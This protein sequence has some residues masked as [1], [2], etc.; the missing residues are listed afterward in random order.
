MT[1][2]PPNS[3]SSRIESSFSESD[4]DQ[5][6]GFGGGSHGPGHGS[7]PARVVTGEIRGLRVGTPCRA[8]RPRLTRL[9]FSRVMPRHTESLELEDPI[10]PSHSGS[11]SRSTL[12]RSADSEA[13]AT[14]EA[15]AAA[16]SDHTMMAAASSV[17]NPS[18]SSPRRRRARRLRSAPTLSGSVRRP[19]GARS[20][21]IQAKSFAGKIRVDSDSAS[22]VAVSGTVTTWSLRGNRPTKLELQTPSLHPSPWQMDPVTETARMQRRSARPRGRD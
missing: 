17:A 6:R 3:P 21:L 10:H 9:S 15:S 22:P 13:A 18:E 19:G 5:S 12:I 16:A 1:R 11:T 8:A 4:S 14:S 20:A 2:S 7:G